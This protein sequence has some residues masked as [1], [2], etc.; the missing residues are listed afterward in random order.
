M[1]GLC[2]QSMSLML[3]R[4]QLAAGAQRSENMVLG[5]VI[6][7]YPNPFILYL[8]RE[9]ENILTRVFFR[10]EKYR[11]EPTGNC[12][13]D[14]KLHCSQVSRSFWVRA[15]M[16]EPLA[17]HG[18]DGAGRTVRSLECSRQALTVT[19]EVVAAEVGRSGQ[20]VVRAGGKGTWGEK[21]PQKPLESQEPSRSSL[22]QHF[23]GQSGLISTIH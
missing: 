9:Q 21:F 4:R 7:Q 8:Q 20:D 22:A 18:N 11:E 17:P 3:R 13:F 14:I 2:P 6:L 19:G 23:I 10:L 1:R 15:M 12:G 5:C 16:T